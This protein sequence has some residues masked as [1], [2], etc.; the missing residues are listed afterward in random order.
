MYVEEIS[1]EGSGGIKALNYTIDGFNV[2]EEVHVHQTVDE[3]YMNELHADS[4]ILI[5]Q[6]IEV[7]DFVIYAYNEKEKNFSAK[8]VRRVTLMNKLTMNSSLK[9]KHHLP[10]IRNNCK[11]SLIVF[12]NRN[13]FLPNAPVGVRSHMKSYH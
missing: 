13:L 12:R 8:T 3:D 10:T 1:I 7:G 11:T 6:D 9:I 4:G 2:V 5:T